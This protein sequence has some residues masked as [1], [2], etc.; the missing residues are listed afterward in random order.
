[1]AQLAKSENNPSGRL[2]LLINPKTK[3]TMYCLNLMV[4]E[5]FIRKLKAIAYEY[6]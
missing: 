2:F 6:N 4:V 5:N 1:M 3:Q